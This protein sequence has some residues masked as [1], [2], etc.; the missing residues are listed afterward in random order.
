MGVWTRK[1]IT[2]IRKNSLALKIRPKNLKM[3][4]NLKINKILF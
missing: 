4:L 2:F 3:L 1:R